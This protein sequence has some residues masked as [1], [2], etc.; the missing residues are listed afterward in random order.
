MTSQKNIH[1]RNKNM[2]KKLNPEEKN[3]LL[4]YVTSYVCI[5]ITWDSHVRHHYVV[6]TCVPSLV[7]S[8][9]FSTG[10]EETSHAR[11]LHPNRSKQTLFCYNQKNFEENISKKNVLETS[12]NVLKRLEKPLEEKCF[13]KRLERKYI[14]NLNN[15]YCVTTSEIIWINKKKPIM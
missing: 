1:E 2:K 5:V 7:T 6:P 3:L 13:R 14:H 10:P 12:W 11:M 9:E 4:Y 15:F 8:R